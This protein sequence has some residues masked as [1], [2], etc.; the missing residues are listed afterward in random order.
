MDTYYY[1]VAGLPDISLDD[2]KLSYTV[3]SFKSEIYPDLSDKDKKVIDLFYLKLDNDNL[4]HLLKDKDYAVVSQ[5]MYS[6]E[7]LLSVIDTVKDGD[8][9]DKKYPSYFCNFISEYFKLNPEDLYKAGD[10][11]AAQY[12]AYAM[13]CKNK[14]VS[15][16]FEFNLNLN[17]IQAALSARKYKLDIASAIV[18]N[19][20]VCESLRTSNARDFGL[21]D[22]LTY[23]EN[24][25]R[26]AEID[27]LVEREKKIDQLKWE[28]LET[29]SFFHYFTIERLFVFLLQLEMIERWISLDK[30]KGSELFRAMIQDLKNDVQIPEEF[31]K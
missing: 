19:T 29:E 6:A 30:E 4:L 8:I 7:E 12:Y 23:L 21:G 26:I 14:F 15:A 20:D 9:P 2:G 24:V 25:Q 16:W 11:L 10:M 17:N 31:R 27:E 5:G 13:N 1:L 3:D 28:W 22:T 18:G